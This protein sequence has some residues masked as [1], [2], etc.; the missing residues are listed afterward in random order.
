MSLRRVAW[1]FAASFWTVFGIVSGLQVWISMITHGHSIVRLLGYYVLVCEAWL[2]A[3][4]GIVWLA[5][6]FPVVPPKRL[7][8]LVHIFA[9]NAIGIAHGLYWLGLLI[10]MKPYDRMTAE[11]SRLRVNEILFARMPL[12]W[13]LYTLVLGGALA[14]DFY[15]RYRERELQAAQLEASLADAR[16]H[17]LELQIQPHF[18][19]NTLNSIS[20]LVRNQRTEKAVTMISGLSELLR[21]TLDHAG[22][23]HVALEQEMAVLRRYLEIQHTR[24][25][26]RMS[27][28]IDLAPEVRRAAVPTLLL[29]PL[30]ENAVRHGIALSAAPGTIDIRAERVGD[31]V[32]IEIFNSGAL[33][34]S[35]G[36]SGIGVRNTR[37]RL[38]H[39]YGDAGRFD[40][41]SAEGGVVASLS[42]PWREVA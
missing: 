17:A 10:L 15:E 18:L 9:A 37:E 3:T 23:Q 34:T 2:A 39:L 27:F 12:E 7:H 31:R 22:E 5:R 1:W 32:Q 30:A 38:Q 20:A 19:F 26:D 13:I 42:I 41:A 29:Q 16:L 14:L 40:L 24:F 4:A 33:T 6:R 25:P 8:I 21:Y 28:S 11:P 35:D 36:G